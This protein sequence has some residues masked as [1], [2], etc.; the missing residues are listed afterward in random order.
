MEPAPAEGLD[1]PGRVRARPGRVRLRARGGGHHRRRRPSGGGRSS[2]PALEARHQRGV[3][4]ATAATGTGR[5]GRPPHGPRAAARGGVGPAQPRRVRP[6]Q[7]VWLLVRTA[8]GVRL[9]RGPRPGRPPRLRQRARGHPRL[10]Q[11]R[12]RE[13]RLR[14][15][16][17]AT[18]P[19]YASPAYASPA[20]ASPAYASPAYASP[21]YASP[22]QTTGI[23]ASSARPAVE[24][25]V[26]RCA[27]R[28]KTA[29][30]TNGIDVVVLD[31][32]LA[33]KTFHSAALDCPP[34]EAPRAR[35][36]FRRGP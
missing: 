19:A 14:Q 31:T 5:A 3:Q 18:S 22:A 29:E 10:R 12:R 32:G 21:A 26:S 36:G 8:P 17:A 23:R 28:L 34:R 6:R 27:E 35:E 4:V 1:R 11:L 13:P 15:S 7:R 2:V 9:G 30:A 25:F 24:P 20:Y 16:C 33:K